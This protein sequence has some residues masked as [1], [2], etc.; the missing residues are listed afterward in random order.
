VWLR[1]G[2]P[3]FA[4]KLMAGEMAE[5]LLLSGQNVTPERLLKHGFEFQYPDLATALGELMSPRS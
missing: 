5:E 1:L 2:V 3:P 4:A